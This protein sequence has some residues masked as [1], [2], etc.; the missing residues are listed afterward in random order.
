MRIGELS[1]RSGASPRAIRYYEELGLL[2]AE[3]RHNGYREFDDASVQS[4]M[5]I[6]ALFQLG[7]TSELVAQ[8]LP[9]TTDA[10]PVA[11]D[12]GAL[13]RRIAEIRDD[14]DA[15]ARRLDATRDELTAFLAANAT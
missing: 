15:K 13:M 7:F 5:T 8:V 14:M 1:D 10:G 6:R 9:C 12:C 2:R 3:R 11:A 4:V